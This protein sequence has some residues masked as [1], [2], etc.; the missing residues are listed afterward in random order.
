M[1]GHDRA[2]IRRFV[3]RLYGGTMGAG[4]VP[5]ETVDKTSVGS[6]R[7]FDGSRDRGT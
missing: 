4:A 7:A 6:C 3:K 1:V 5:V 2:A